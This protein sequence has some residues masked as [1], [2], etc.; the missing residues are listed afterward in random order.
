MASDSPTAQ[1]HRTRQRVSRGYAYRP[2]ERTVDGE[3][4]QVDRDGSVYRMVGSSRRR[5]REI[6]VISKVYARLRRKGVAA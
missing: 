4:Y 3:R 2:Q 6:R 1:H 5:V